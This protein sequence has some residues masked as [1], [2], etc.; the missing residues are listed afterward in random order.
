MAGHPNNPQAILNNQKAE[1][2]VTAVEALDIS[3]I[4]LLFLDIF[5]KLLE[6]YFKYVLFPIAAAG[7]IIKAVLAW[8]QVTLEHDEL[9]GKLKS[10]LILRAIVETLAATAI[11]VAV[12][13]A[14][15]FASVFSTISPIIFAAT[16]GAKSAFHLLC[17]VFYAGKISFAQD[18]V[19][20]N[21]CKKQIYNNAMASVSSGL[22]SLAVVCVMILA[23]PFLA[24]IGI[25]AGLVMGLYALA[26]LGS[27]VFKSLKKPQ[28]TS[29][30][31]NNPTENH[32]GPDRP[33]TNNTKL[34][35]QIQ[36]SPE[37]ANTAGDVVIEIVDAPVAISGKPVPPTN[38]F[39]ESPQLSRATTNNLFKP[40]PDLPDEAPIEPS[41]SSLGHHK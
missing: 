12:I 1:L 21:E 2:S 28:P 41:P 18:P 26:A 16:L 20:K 30:S 40:Q 17:T 33:L 6:T 9:T 15:A 31:S 3:A 27:L 22:T 11:T 38:P 14:L 29:S 39:H 35:N 10:N 34:H 13:G 8:R 25:A 37:K 5:R 7:N 36:F 19:N 24:P 4:F 23:K 32:D